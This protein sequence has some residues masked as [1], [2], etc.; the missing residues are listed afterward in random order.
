MVRLKNDFDALDELLNEDSAFANTPF[1]VEDERRDEDLAA[2]TP[3]R[4]AA[5]LNMMRY[6]NR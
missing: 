3:A 4:F 5:L 1:V 2:K 6:L